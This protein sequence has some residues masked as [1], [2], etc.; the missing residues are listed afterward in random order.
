MIMISEIYE[1]RVMC[2]TTT[3]NKCKEKNVIITTIKTVFV[4][5]YKSNDFSFDQPAVFAKQITEGFTSGLRRTRS[6]CAR[7]LVHIKIP[8]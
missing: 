2:T 8:K 3:S 4:N 5:E 6:V 1:E 7:P